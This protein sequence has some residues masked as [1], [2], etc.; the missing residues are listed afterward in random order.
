MTCNFKFKSRVKRNSI[1]II[2]TTIFCL[3]L[4]QAISA[5]TKN[6]ENAFSNFE[7]YSDRYREVAYCHLNKSI[8]IKGEM[9]GFSSYVFDKKTKT[10]STRTKNLYCVILDANNEVLKSKLVK[11]EEGFANN[12]FTIDSSFTSGNYTFKAY[13]NWMKNFNQMDAYIKKFQVLD[14]EDNDD[15][16]N[17]S[18]D[19]SF[20]V[21]FLPEGGHLINTVKTTVGV[22]IKNTNGLGVP[23]LEGNIYNSDNRLIEKFK[24]NSFG[25]GRFLLT[26]AIGK[27]YRA[28]IS[29]KGKLLTFR[30]D[31]IKSKGISINVSPIKDKLGVDFRTN[32][33]TLNDIQDRDYN[34]VIHNG[35]NSRVIKINMEE[36]SVLKII[37]KNMLFSG[38]NI[39]TLLNENFKPV[40]ERLYFNYE[41]IEIVDSGE[42][43]FKT[44]KDSTIISIPLLEP[45]KLIPNKTNISVSILPIQ[46]KADKNHHNIISYS[47]LQPYLKGYIENAKYYFTEIDN[48]KKY[49]LDNLLITQGWS[50]YDWNLIFEDKVKPVHPFEDGIV[51]KANKSAKNE[52][53]FVLYPLKANGSLTIDLPESKDYFV[54]NKLYPEEDEVLSIGTLDNKG[55]TKPSKLYTQFFPSE[56]PNYYYTYEALE[57]PSSKTP[58]EIEESQFSF[59]F[60]EKTQQLE[61][62]VIETDIKD[63]KIEKLKNDMMS[64]FYEIDDGIRRSNVSLASYINTFVFDYTVYEAGGTFIIN[65]RN[66]NSL[67]VQSQAPIIYLDDML[68]NDLNYFFAYNMNIVDYISVNPTGLGEGFL[69]ANGVIRIYTSL[70]FI[71]KAQRPSFQN[72]E[73]P[74]AFSKIKQFYVPKYQSYTNNFYKAYG[75]I[76]WIPNAEVDSYGN[77]NFTLYNPSKNDLRIN[78]EGY[79]NDNG[80]ISETKEIKIRDL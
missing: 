76:D 6:L 57:V 68:I 73:I 2:C 48:K 13:T 52:N 7:N 61:E 45:N 71:E 79:I 54:V 50:S 77:I 30:I 19:N 49:Q 24:T 39:L 29:H 36:T 78:I 33:E 35:D 55:K 22:I 44:A 23:N 10:P 70:D 20:D 4:A 59:P 1:A 47:Y 21:Q 31:N 60:L 51:L 74:L 66:P 65:R 37:D 11:V 56:I 40:L 18:N 38:M 58:S 28:E 41:G 43:D 12:T 63:I 62:V 27:N 80:F 69:G 3:G 15:I 5:Q 16:R 72:F 17:V 64:D 32:Q 34:L 9:L 8:Y 14:A 53:K 25:I 75:V 42:I 46:T 67:V 26:P